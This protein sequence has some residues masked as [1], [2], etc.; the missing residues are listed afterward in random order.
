MGD[1]NFDPNSVEVASFSPLPAGE[2][3]AAIVKSDWKKTKSGTGQY[4]ELIVEILDGESKGRRV[5]DR[6]NLH[7]SNPKAVEIAEKRLQQICKGQERHDQ[8]LRR[9]VESHDAHRD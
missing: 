7:N 9:T 4:L 2:Y 6:L 3:V 8:R 1:L 5:F